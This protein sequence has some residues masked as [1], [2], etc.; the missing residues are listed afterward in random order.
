MGGDTLDPD[1]VERRRF[2]LEVFLWR[3][4]GHVVVCYD[5]QFLGFL[6]QDEGWRDTCKDTGL[7]LFFSWGFFCEYWLVFR[8][9]ADD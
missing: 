8:V 6:Q 9:F 1:F 3:I 2:A 7:F 5:E 4:A